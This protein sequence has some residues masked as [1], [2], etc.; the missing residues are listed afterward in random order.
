MAVA[1][2]LLRGD[3]LVWTDLVRLYHWIFHFNESSTDLWLVIALFLEW[4]EKHRP[5]WIEY[6]TF[7]A[8]HIIGIDKLPGAHLVRVGET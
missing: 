8:R 1:R 2:I 6:W 5:P 7:M 3:G 4:L